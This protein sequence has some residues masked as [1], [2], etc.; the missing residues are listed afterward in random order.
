MMD[1]IDWLD[2]LAQAESADTPLTDEELAL[3]KRGL[4]D[5]NARMWNVQYVHAAQRA[6]EG[7]DSGE[8]LAMMLAAIPAPTFLLPVIAQVGIPQAG[9]GSALTAVDDKFLREAFD[10][11]TE[12]C[13]MS[14][15]DA[16]RHLAKL[17]GVSDKTMAR[18]LARTEP[19]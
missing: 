3:W 1:S 6:I 5:G 18:S 11:L 4:L 14:K 12:H 17:R 13:S 2:L 16:R 10:R 7:N 9:R 8:L 19:P 15:A